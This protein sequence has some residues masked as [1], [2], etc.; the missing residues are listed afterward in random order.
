MLS[1][2][3]PELL[4]LTI[5]ENPAWHA[6]ICIPLSWCFTWWLKAAGSSGE[7]TPPRSNAQPMR[8]S[9]GVYIPSPTRGWLWDGCSTLAAGN[10]QQ[11]G[12]PVVHTG[13]LP[14]GVFLWLISPLTSSAS[15]ISSPIHCSDSNPCFKWRHISQCLVKWV[16][17]RAAV[18]GCPWLSTRPLPALGSR[19]YTG[20]G[21]TQGELTL[22]G[23]TVPQ[24]SAIPEVPEYQGLSRPRSQSNMGL[25]Q[26]IAQLLT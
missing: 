8:D 2:L 19:G 24:G 6:S 16:N 12:T 21:P 15:G 13:D 26:A 18:L 22:R 10:S 4:D 1:V 17:L 20:T 11:V 7:F 3:C 14:D 25:P 5:L 9:S 23:T